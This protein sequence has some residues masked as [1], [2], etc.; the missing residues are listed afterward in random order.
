MRNE[1][2]QQITIKAMARAVIFGGLFGGVI[3]ILMLLLS[4]FFVLKMKTLSQ[5]AVFAAA[6]ISS[7]VSA[8]LA[9]FLASRILKARGMA[10]GALS[11][12]LLFILVLLTG[13]IF[14]SDGLNL[15]TLM[16]FTAMLLSGAFGGILGVN[17]RTRRR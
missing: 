8:F 9:G 6:I 3:L 5:T 10:V 16:R 4:A 11:A 12:M 14:S 13:T 2:S 17:R 7:C 1:K 15:D